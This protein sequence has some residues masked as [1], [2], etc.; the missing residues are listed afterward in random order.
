MI[1][2]KPQSQVMNTVTVLALRGVT[3]VNCGRVPW[4][5]LITKPKSL[6]INPKPQV[7]ITTTR[8]TGSI[9]PRLYL[10]IGIYHVILLSSVENILNSVL[11]F[12]YLT[13]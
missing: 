1:G 12:P 10:C 7:P 2:G 13:H 4:V 5:L 3:P 8:T 6:D 11:L 9:H